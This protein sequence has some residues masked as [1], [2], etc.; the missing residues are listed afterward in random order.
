MSVELLEWTG[1]NHETSSHGLKE[2][3]THVIPG[4]HNE[5]VDTFS[6]S[7]RL[8]SQENDEIDSCAHLP[9]LL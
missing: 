7:I 6:R 8:H 4:Q 2:L 3:D 1:G 9:K 5:A